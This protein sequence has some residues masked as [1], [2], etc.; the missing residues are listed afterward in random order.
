MRN[1]SMKCDNK[2]EKY[3]CNCDTGVNK[4]IR[5]MR[6]T[7]LICEINKKGIANGC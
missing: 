3:G 5:K 4:I 2:G 1:N 6:N 7:S